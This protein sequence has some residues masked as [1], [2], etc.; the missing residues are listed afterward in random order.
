MLKLGLSVF[1]G[2]ILAVAGVSMSP[3]DA[4]AFGTPS[5]RNYVEPE[6]QLVRRRRYGRMRIYRGYRGYSAR[7]FVAPP[8]VMGPPRAMAPARGDR[9]PHRPGAFWPDA[10]GRIFDDMFGPYG[11]PNRG[12]T[13]PPPPRHGA[14]NSPNMR[15]Q[16]AP[17][18]GHLVGICGEQADELA[19]WPLAQIEKAVRPT[20]GQRAALTALR[21]AALSAATTLHAACPTESS[22]GPAARL[23]G[24]GNSLA[25]VGRAIDTLRPAVDTF[26][27]SLDEEQKAQLIKLILLGSQRDGASSV[28]GSLARVC[29]DPSLLG[30]TKW[31]V[32]RIRSAIRASDEQRAA[33]EELWSTSHRATKALEVE[34]PTDTPLTP[35]R[36]LETMRKQ[37]DAILE[38]VSLLRPV[39]ARFY[40]TLNDEQKRRFDSMS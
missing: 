39:L 8:G 2:T 3:P 29:E 25:A 24:V 36:R 12:D 33:L 38:A 27:M 35:S 21:D 37:L 30:F 5:L 6:I 4:A 9:L 28:R 34:C 16:P 18:L 15:E 19:N 1:A 20:E 40:D 10:Y 11:A 7:F 23:E 13:L 31:S 17:A 22:S 26:Y 32:E 14:R